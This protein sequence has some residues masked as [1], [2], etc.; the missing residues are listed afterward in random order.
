[1]ELLVLLKIMLTVVLLG[2]ISL[3]I[4]VFDILLLKPERL[5]SKL[6]KQGISGPPP[7]FLLGNIRDIKRKPQSKVSTAPCE[8]VQVVLTH[9][10]SSTLFPSFEQ[11]RKE[12]GPIFMFSLGNIQVLY[13]NQPDVVKE[14]STYTSL[15]FGKPSYQHKENGPLLGQGILT[16]NGASWAHQRKILAPEFYMDKVKVFF[17]FSAPKDKQ[18]S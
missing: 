8:E 18:K 9:N 7:S 16:S 1:M 2:I 15:D 11:W 12:Y 4:Y 10:C 13:M 14:I 17:P 6:R 5:R 3:L